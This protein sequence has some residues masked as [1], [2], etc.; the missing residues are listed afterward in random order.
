MLLKDDK[1][2]ELV[3]RGFINYFGLQ[4]F[5]SNMVNTHQIGILILQGEYQKAI[6][7]I[8]RKTTY[9]KIYIGQEKD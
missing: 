3:E 6:V 4:R 9:R 8:F 2:K 7:S 5:G 1:C